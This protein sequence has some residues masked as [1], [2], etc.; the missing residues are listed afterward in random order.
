MGANAVE[1]FFDSCKESSESRG[2]I[3]ST[4]K[5][6]HNA[7]VDSMTINYS[8][9]LCGVGHIDLYLVHGP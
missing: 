7:G 6:K 2:N 9:K 3:F 1:Q 8:L 5:S 4:T